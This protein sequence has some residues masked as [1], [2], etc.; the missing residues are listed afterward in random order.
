MFEDLTSFQV[1]MW[2]SFFV[3]LLPGT[4]ILTAKLVQYFRRWGEVKSS[5]LD[6]LNQTIEISLEEKSISIPSTIIRSP[7]SQ[8]LKKILLIPPYAVSAKRYLYLATAFALNNYE[9]HLIENRRTIIKINKEKSDGRFFVSELVKKLSPTAIIAS[10]VFFSLFLPE[11]QQNLNIRF[12]FIRPILINKHHSLVFSLFLSIPWISNLFL[13]QI[14]QENNK[15]FSI[16]SRVLCIFPKI[17]LKNR[18][19]NIYFQNLEIQLLQSRFSFRDKETMVFSRI[20]QFIGEF[21]S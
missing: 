15:K 4:I 6:Y 12:A 18:W 5:G 11:M 20:L 3:F 1:Y 13:P 17:F 7:T 21:S 8:N 16:A 9:V 2:I 19:V 10:D 14:R